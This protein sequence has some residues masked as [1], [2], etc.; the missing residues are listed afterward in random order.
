ML[1]KWSLPLVELEAGQEE[2]KSLRGRTFPKNE[3][4]VQWLVGVIHW[5]QAVLGQACE[6]KYSHQRV[7]FFAIGILG[8]SLAWVVDSKRGDLTIGVSYDGLHSYSQ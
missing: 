8:E 7:Y 2:C 1:W 6:E 3:G 4:T 5:Q